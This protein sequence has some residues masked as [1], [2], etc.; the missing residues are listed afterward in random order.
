MNK[1]GLLHIGKT[2]GTAANTALK[3]NNKLGTGEFVACYKHRVGLPEVASDNMCERLMFIIREPV[4]RY[5]SAFNSRLRMGY[6]RYSG[7]WNPKE[8]LAFSR[9]KTPNSLAEALSAED[10]LLRQHAQDAMGG[11]K[12]LRR[13]Y[14]KYL[15]SVNLLEQEKDR[16][17]FIG[18]TE[19]FDDDF[20]IMRK[21]LHLSPEISLPKDDYGAHR[22]PEGFEKTVSELG[23][24]NVQDYYKGDY[25]I[26]D[27]C[28]KRR[29]ELI[30]IR[31]AELEAAAQ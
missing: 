18:A 8:E 26:Y 22:T 20:E 14:T 11:I 3:A 15:G 16:I 13:A 4:A 5:I 28:V 27:W 2:G 7:T 17:Y 30:A 23:R 24:K 31:T 12:H 21:F 10:P 6:P 25:E 29:A 19:H 9:F 1:Y